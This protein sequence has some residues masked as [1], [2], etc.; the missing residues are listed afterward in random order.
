MTGQGRSGFAATLVAVALCFVP[1]AASQG[2]LP[3]WGKAPSPNGGFGPNVLAAVDTLSATDAWAVG[4]YQQNTVKHPLVQ[5]WDGT[6]W[7]IVPTPDVE[8]SEF[9]G[10][11]AVAGDDVWMVGGYENTGDLLIMHWDGSSI[12]VVPH[13]IP[14]VL[15][16]LY[17]VTAVSTDDVWAV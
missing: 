10:V 11:A 7:T 9:L 13:S 16:R 15:D 1:A 12:S 4:R 14:G 3:A 8:E 2:D 6:E 5:H 17:A